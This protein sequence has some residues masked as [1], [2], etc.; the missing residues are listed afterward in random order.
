MFAK[1]FARPGLE[2]LLQSIPGDLCKPG[3]CKSPAAIWPRRN[4]ANNKCFGEEK[5]KLFKL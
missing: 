3:H 1:G 5:K 4:I 2:S